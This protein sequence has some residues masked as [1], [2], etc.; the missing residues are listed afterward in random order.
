MRILNKLNPN[1]FF[2]NKDFLLNKNFMIKEIKLIIKQIKW[3]FI[4]L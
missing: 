3:F 2:I 1:I 4:R